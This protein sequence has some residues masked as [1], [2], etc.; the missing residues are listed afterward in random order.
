MFGL[1]KRYDKVVEEV[2]EVVFNGGAGALV[3]AV[4]LLTLG[5]VF[6]RIKT[7]R[8]A[9]PVG[10]KKV[11]LLNTVYSLY[12][13]GGIR[14]F[15]EGLRWNVTTQCSKNAFRWIA[16]GKVNAVYSQIL[17]QSWKERSPV[18]QP[19]LTS[20]SL[21]LIETT[22]FVCPAE[23]MKTRNMTRSAKEKLKMGA[24]VQQEGFRALY[25]GYTAMLIRYCV[26][27]SSYLIVSKELN[28]F[29][30]KNRELSLPEEFAVNASTGAINVFF[31]A[32]FDTVKT[33]LQKEN[34][35]RASNSY[36]AMRK[37]TLQHG[38]RALWSGAGTKTLHSM[39]YSGIMLTSMKYTG[40][41][42]PSDK[43]GKEKES[44]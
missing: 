22:A 40:A 20:L 39:W 42:D 26:S 1:E 13:A 38:F 34:A 18:L 11:S 28:D 16:V 5:H 12:Q 2:K 23:V 25:Q 9:Y 19:L 41:Y 3:S 10:I 44:K 37:I 43:V 6:D 21:A 8:Q 31:T 7:E 14:K 36:Q 30:S 33:Q 35:L 27:W 15:Y 17:P 4:E 32:P 29:F 24:I